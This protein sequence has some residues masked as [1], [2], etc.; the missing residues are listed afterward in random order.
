[1]FKLGGQGMPSFA[2]NKKRGDFF[3]RTTIQVPEQLTDEE[4]KLF[5]KLA[6]K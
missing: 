5:E 4:R 3:V 1:L 2:D 6:D